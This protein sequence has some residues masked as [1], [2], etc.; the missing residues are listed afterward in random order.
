[1]ANNTNEA[2]NVNS[3]VQG[4]LFALVG[5]GVLLILVGLVMVFASAATGSGGSAGVVIFI[6]P[7]PIVFGAGPDAGLLVL[8]G[9]VLALVMMVLFVVF[10]RRVPNPISFV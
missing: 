3:G 10:R 1:M 4:W 8:V 7:I 6:G 2:E 5:V 9:V